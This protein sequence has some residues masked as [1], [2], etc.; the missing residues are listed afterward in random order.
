VRDAVK[1]FGKWAEFVVRV[2]EK[3][4]RESGE[5]MSEM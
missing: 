2:R 3:T 5:I 4:G 1:V